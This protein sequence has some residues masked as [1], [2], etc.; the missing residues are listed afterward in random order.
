TSMLILPGPSEE[1]IGRGRARKNP[2]AKASSARPAMLPAS[3]RTNERQS[4]RECRIFRRPRDPMLGPIENAS[5]D[6]LATLRRFVRKPRER[7]E[8]CELCSAPLSR[9][10]QHLL[11]FEKHTVLCACEACALLFGNH[12]KQRYCRI[13]RDVRLLRDFVLDEQGWAS[14][15]IPIN[16]A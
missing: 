10:H 11:E 7:A 2:G 9:E 4:I 3:T 5:R 6:G 12:A 8:A 13:P 1:K 14:L 16:L 15:L